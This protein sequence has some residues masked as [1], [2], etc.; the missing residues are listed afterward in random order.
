M[1]YANDI[2]ALAHSEIQKRLEKAKSIQAAH[3]AA[4]RDIPDIYKP[5]VEIVSTKDRLAEIIFSKDTNTRERIEKVK[6]QNLKN[7]SLLISALESNGFSKDFLDV[8]YTCEI[9]RDTGYVN[10]YRCECL[11]SLLDKYTID[12]LNEQC[13]IK[14]RD[15]SEFDIS[16]YPES[17]KTKNGSDIDVR[18]MMKEHL[19]YC[20]DY[21]DS[22]TSD[23]T[24]IF[25]LGATGLGKTFLS[26][27]IAKSVLYKGFS[28][29]FDSVQNYL[30]D[31]EREH[32]GKS[33]GDTLE[34]I[35]SA[36]LLILDDLGSEFSSSFNSSV[37]YNIINSR[38]NQCLP[39]IVSSNLSFDE[40]TKRYDDRVIS[41]LTG[42]FKPM[43]F[44]GNDIRQL[45]RQS[46]IY[47]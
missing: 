29:A 3:V 4:I 42:L 24:S 28:V 43:R 20:M 44:I 27:C 1:K 5:Y 9:C 26:S 34:T 36:D 46:G 14:L 2:I 45:K 47:N 31:I 11:N 30:R 40:L 7:Q 32:F 33:D 8:H 38:T 17:Y 23:S 21:A 22:F 37:I 12:K 35:L 25:M 13:K 39:T 19:H 10:G 18:A 41:R 6:D 15:F 16:Y